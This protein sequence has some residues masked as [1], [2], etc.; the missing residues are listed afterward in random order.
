MDR[1]QLGFGQAREERK[2]MAEQTEISWT[3]A[4]FN[5]WMGCVNVSPA[6]EHCY[7]EELVT[8]SMGLPVWGKDAPRK[9]TSATYWTQP[10]YWN[11]DAQ[12]EGKRQRVFCGSLCDVMED[13]RDLDPIRSDLYGLIERTPWL[14]WLLLTKRPQNFT[15]FLS[16]AWRV[17]PPSNIWG[18]TTVESSEYLW[19]IEAMRALPF[20]IH[21]LSIE[22]LLEDMPTLGDHL[23][24]IEWVIVGGES[25]PGAR[26]MHPDWARRIRD[27]CLDRQI[28]FHFKQ[29]GEWSPNAPEVAREQYRFGDGLVMHRVGKHAA[30]RLLDGRE[31]LE[32]PQR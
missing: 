13:R 17:N 27:I 9:R 21:G 14:D 12:K 19:R 2:K 16:E 20:A 24:G 11:R 29:W 8:G 25:G 28:P 26:P 4:T 10:Y 32:F 30:G 22:P 3:D 15:R 6:C 7:A 5:P 18:M 31:W 1:Q 23:D